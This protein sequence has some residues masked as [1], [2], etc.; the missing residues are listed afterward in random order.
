MPVAD[1]VTRFHVEYFGDVSPPQDPRPPIGE[2]N[3]L[4][5]LSGALLP[6]AL[7]GPPPFTLMRLGR[8]RFTDGPWCGS[9]AMQFDADLLRVRAVRITLRLRAGR[10]GINGPQ[11]PDLEFAVEL[12]PRNLAVLR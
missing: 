8:E 3:C 1:H 4:Y 6:G 11:V 2:A 5:D 7:L 9:G 10:V 12:A